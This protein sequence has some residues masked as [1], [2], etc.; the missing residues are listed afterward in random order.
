[1]I[2]YQAMVDQFLKDHET[3]E[4]IDQMMVDDDIQLP[5]T[6]S[7]TL[8]DGTAGDGMEW[9]LDPTS[10][11]LLDMNKFETVTDFDGCMK[12]VPWPWGDQEY[13]HTA[14]ETYL[15]PEDYV[16]EYQCAEMGEVLREE[17]MEA[18]VQQAI[19]AGEEMK[20]MERKG[21]KSPRKKAKRETEG[22][23]VRQSS[24]IA[25]NNQVVRGRNIYRH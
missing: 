14:P 18:S 24:T 20:R 23:K 3:P 6:S 21:K 22:E 16:M 15:D 7:S 10:F 25:F 8:A 9:D 17:A 12:K 4:N 19:L 13:R 5:T 2:Y 11:H 1:M